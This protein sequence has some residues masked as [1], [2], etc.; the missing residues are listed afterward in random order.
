MKN[1][2]FGYIDFP[3]DVSISINETPMKIENP[4]REII[5]Y[6]VNDEKL[7]MKGNH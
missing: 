1:I 4:F 5:Q 3:Q 6:V 2:R 7:A